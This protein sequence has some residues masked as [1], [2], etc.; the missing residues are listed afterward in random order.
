[1][2]LNKGMLNDEAKGPNTIKTENSSAPALW[3]KREA[4]ITRS[5]EQLK[6]SGSMEKSASQLSEIRWLIAFREIF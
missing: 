5:D 6:S 1:M 4:Y 2:E 3:G